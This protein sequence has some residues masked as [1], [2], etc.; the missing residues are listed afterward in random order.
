MAIESEDTKVDLWGY[1]YYDCTMYGT[2]SCKL[3]KQIPY[4]TMVVITCNNHKP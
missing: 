4:L 3:V 1:D 2:R